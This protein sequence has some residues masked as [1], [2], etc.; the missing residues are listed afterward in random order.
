[1]RALVYV[2]FPASVLIAFT[3]LL[4]ALLLDRLPKRLFTVLWLVAAVRL[5]I[6]FSAVLPS[7]LA[8]QQPVDALFTATAQAHHGLFNAVGMAAAPAPAQ[9]RLLLCVW[10]AGAAGMAL[11]FTLAHIRFLRRCREALPAEVPA[12][13]AVVR[14]FGLRRR[15]RVLVC[16]QVSTPLTY[17]LLRPVILLPPGMEDAPEGTVRCALTHELVHVRAL[18]VPLKYLLAAAL[19]LH[20]YNPLVWL[21]Y[22]LANRDIELSCD[23]QSLRRLGGDRAQYAAV[24]IDLEAGR[25]AGP[26]LS[27][28]G[29]QAVRERVRQAM[30]FK[31][32]GAGACILAAALLLC[33]GAVFVSPTEVAEESGNSAPLATATPASIQQVTGGPLIPARGTPPPFGTLPERAVEGGVPLSPAPTPYPVPAVS[34]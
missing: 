33:A 22:A 17:G 7:G 29:A 32:H 18:H 20:W 34:Q 28:L 3:A 24:L 31:R 12:A 13:D 30:L 25:G 4:R 16:R 15:V 27:G 26:L 5:V 2:I 9:R 19:C 8:P 10:A 11:Y 6:P 23:E 21:M 1:M 14:N